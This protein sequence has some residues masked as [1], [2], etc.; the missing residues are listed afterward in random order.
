VLATHTNKHH[1][2]QPLT[3][4]LLVA[5][6]HLH[7]MQLAALKH[8]RCVARSQQYAA[9]AVTSA[10]ARRDGERC[11]QPAECSKTDT[12]YTALSLMPTITG[13]TFAASPR[14]D[15]CP[16]RKES[17]STSHARNP[18]NLSFF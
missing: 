10:T 2:P 6:R 13:N 9:I 11:F 17:S 5:R 3:D 8:W 14:T 15:I 16:Q 1:V 18:V 12:N 7:L 4:R